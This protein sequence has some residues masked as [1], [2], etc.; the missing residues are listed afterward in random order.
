MIGFATGTRLQKCR[1]HDW[2]WKDRV[3]LGSLFGPG[4]GKRWALL[5]HIVLTTACLTR[6]A[7]PFLHRPSG[8]GM[9][10]DNFGSSRFPECCKTR[11]KPSPSKWSVL[12]SVGIAGRFLFHHRMGRPWVFSAGWQGS[13]CSA[14]APF[15]HPKTPHRRQVPDPGNQLFRQRRPEVSWE[16]T[17][18]HHL[19]DLPSR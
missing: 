5:R 4:N 16:Q 19:L 8:Q 17:T 1:L 13:Q 18:A 10:L 11:P 14:I 12:R 6:P 3:V 9:I 7:Y 2:N 15:T